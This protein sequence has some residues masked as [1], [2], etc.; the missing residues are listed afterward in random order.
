MPGMVYNI[1]IVK[2][3]SHYPADGSFAALSSRTTAR[4]KLGS[5]GAWQIASSYYTATGGTRFINLCHQFEREPLKPL[6]KRLS[7]TKWV[8]TT[9]WKLWENHRFLLVR[10]AYVKPF[11]TKPFNA[12]NGRISE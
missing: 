7:G 12:W 4:R 1:S 10:V 11:R 6:S 2:A 8:L 5:V 3:L 9:T